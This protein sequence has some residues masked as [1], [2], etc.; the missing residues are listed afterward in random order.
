[1]AGKMATAAGAVDV[2]LV[3]I[4]SVDFGKGFMKAATD[5]FRIVELIW[6]VLKE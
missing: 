6:H 5:R 2:V 4:L 3:L 1:M